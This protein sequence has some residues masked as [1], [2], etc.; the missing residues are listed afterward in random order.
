VPI[1]LFR[2]RRYKYFII[3]SAGRGDMVFTDKFFQAGQMWPVSH[4][5]VQPDQRLT[6]Q[7]E[8]RVEGVKA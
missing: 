2:Q 3:I 5:F 7:K 4:L 8:K 1:V 6:I